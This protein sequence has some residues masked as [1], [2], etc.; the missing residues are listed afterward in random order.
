MPMICFTSPKGGVGKTM[1]AANLAH[2]LARAGRRVLALDLDPQNAL[3]LHFGM[4]LG[5][6]SGLFTG[7]SG[8]LAWRA[9]VQPTPW[10]VYLLPHGTV[11][12]VGT[13]TGRMAGPLAEMLRDILSDPATLLVVDTPAG[14]S[15]GLTTVLPFATLVVLPLLAD[16]GSIAT[17]PDI[18]SGRFFGG[19]TTGS[20]V[21]TRTR[22]VVNQVEPQARLSLAVTKALME[23][24]GQALL[25][26]VG[27]DESVG[28]ALACGQPL[29]AFAP[30]SRAAQD[31]GGVLA[32]LDATLTTL[33]A[34]G[35]PG[36]PMSTS[37][38]L[39][40]ALPPTG[41]AWHAVGPGGP[42]GYPAAGQP[43]GGF[44]SGVPQSV[45]SGGPLPAVAPWPPAP[46][47]QPATW[48][49][50]APGPS[51]PWAPQAPG[52]AAPWAAQ[53]PSPAALWA[54]Q[55]PGPQPYAHA[56]WPG[57]QPSA[58]VSWPGPQPAAAPAPTA[59]PP[60]W[61]AP[62]PVPQAG[63]AAQ[64]PGATAWPGSGP[65]PPAH[66]APQDAAAQGLGPDVASTQPVPDGAGPSHTPLRTT[67]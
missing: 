8:A 22:F 12:A 23:R 11:P 16:G 48:S 4:P 66:G 35:G 13:G 7:E 51:G 10:G 58:N 67:P 31:L 6:R 37:A 5:E 60:S 52:P 1:L 32:A 18:E 26:V 46:Q 44:Q 59:A 36:T 53:A 43:P 63:A 56:S 14:P 49:A 21:A 57:P 2:G 20:L 3:R 27:R 17:L 50:P 30:Q 54:A 19:G 24:F 47:A 62:P 42:A 34:G 45:P 38:M 29:A 9:T 40:A 33:E 28:E 25:G 15:Q 55:A 39:A 65:P 41:P 64:P 61:T